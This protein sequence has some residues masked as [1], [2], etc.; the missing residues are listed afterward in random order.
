MKDLKNASMHLKTH[1][2]YPATKQELVDACNHMSEFSE[3]DK[4]WFA[5]HLPE[6]TYNS[7]EEVMRATG[8]PMEQAGGATM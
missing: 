4:T 5:E 7:A 6:G 1:M 8:M 2:D 3:E